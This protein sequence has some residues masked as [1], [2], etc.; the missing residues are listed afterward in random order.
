MQLFWFAKF[1]YKDRFQKTDFPEV[2]FVKLF[3]M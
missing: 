3:S 1:L 2:S